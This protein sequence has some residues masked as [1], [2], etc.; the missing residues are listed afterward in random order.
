MSFSLLSLFRSSQPA[1]TSEPDD[2]RDTQ[3]FIVEKIT[4]SREKL[5][6]PSFVLDGVR[7]ADGKIK[8]ALL[9]F[10]RLRIQIRSLSEERNLTVVGKS[11][12]VLIRLAAMI[13][14]EVERVPAFLFPNSRVKTDWTK[15]WKAALSATLKQNREGQWIRIYL[16]GVLEFAENNDQ[17]FYDVLE[18]SVCG[19]ELL[20]ENV[21]SA[22]SKAVNSQE[23]V[24]ARYTGQTYL[25][26]S[27][28]GNLYRG[29]F[30]NRHDRHNETLFA[31]APMT[32][33]ER[34]IRMSRF[35]SFCA[36]VVDA[37]VVKPIL[38]GLKALPDDQRKVK[39]D[40]LLE[41]AE[42]QAGSL[43]RVVAFER[44]HRVIFRP[45]RPMLD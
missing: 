17:A 13:S 31:Y 7:S 19:G 22:A 27:R 14:G 38:A 40:A 43:T 42:H 11:V 4:V 12:S 33:E 15:I 5:A 41:A 25:V 29:A 9:R 8:P 39:I 2:E 36:D 18:G 16:D 21:Q 45:E 35:V 10:S 24:P 30:T 26:V 32:I 3:K 34:S 28:S 37:L 23:A 6:L 44:G 20:E 1:S